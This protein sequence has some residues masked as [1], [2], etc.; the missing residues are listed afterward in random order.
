MIRRKFIKL[1]A[2]S[3]LSIFIPFKELKLNPI[4]NNKDLN[5]MRDL[6][7][8][9]LDR[10]SAAVKIPKELL[11]KNPP[12]AM[13]MYKYGELGEPSKKIRLDI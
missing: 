10:I 13:T 5:Q 6:L 1:L 7:E 11:F 4:E 8:E 3:G 9:S 2:I 12:S